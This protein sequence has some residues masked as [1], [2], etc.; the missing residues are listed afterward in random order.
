MEGLCSVL[1][2]HAETNSALPGDAPMRFG[3]LTVD[4]RREVMSCNMTV[5]EYNEK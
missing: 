5:P 1:V 2:T 4:K 3:E